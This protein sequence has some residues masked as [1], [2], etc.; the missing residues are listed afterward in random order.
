MSR[1]LDDGFLDPEAFRPTVGSACP[2]SC[3]PRALREL[4]MALG[5][6]AC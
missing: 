6:P 2:V 5:G 4:A 1:R 3:A